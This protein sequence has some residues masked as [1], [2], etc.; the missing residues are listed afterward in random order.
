MAN[1]G[2]LGA[3]F[4]IS[5]QDP[6]NIVRTLAYDLALS[7][8][9]R[10]QAVSNELNS[11][12]H[13]TSLRIREQVDRLLSKPSGPAQT[14]NR[15]IVIVI[16]ALDE[17][18]ENDEDYHDKDR[19]IP[20]LVS[21]FKHR[22]VKVFVTSRN[23]QYIANFFVEIDHDAFKLHHMDKSDASRD[24]RSY[25]EYQFHQL[26]LSR[27]LVCADWPST[28]D[29]DV[30]TK[31]TGHLFIYAST[32]MTFVSATRFDPI[33]RL[34]FV[35]K[36]ERDSIKRDDVF[37]PLDK[38]YTHIIVAAVTHNRVINDQLSSYCSILCDSH[39]SSLCWLHSTSGTMNM[40][41][42]LISSPCHQ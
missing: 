30:L 21:A 6:R 20:L 18:V 17:S 10:A 36:H 34:D 12:P 40:C 38:L 32:I 24:I 1:E 2:F 15:S 16:D 35:L 11:T 4:F 37:G 41:C 27:R 23:E 39:P 13:L 22:A 29:L 28:F 8:W 31:L 33:Q 25:Y 14:D 7:D 19:L 3:S 42:V 9:S 5:R 26:V